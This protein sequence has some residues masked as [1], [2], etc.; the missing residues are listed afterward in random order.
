MSKDVST[1]RALT[2]EAVRIV[3]LA[4]GLSRGWTNLE[5]VFRAE[6]LDNIRFHA[7]D[8]LDEKKISEKDHDDFTA[9]VD[10]FQRYN[11]GEGTIHSKEMLYEKALDLAIN[12]IH[13]CVEKIK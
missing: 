2:T 3:N 10:T 7:R 4:K 5:P 11:E 8:L 13:D 1:C 9:V 6:H 12:A